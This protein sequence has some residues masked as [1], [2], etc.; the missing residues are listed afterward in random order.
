MFLHLVGIF[1]TLG[2]HQSFLVDEPSTDTFP[3]KTGLVD[4]RPVT[5]RIVALHWRDGYVIHH[6]IGQKL[7]DERVVLDHPLDVRKAIVAGDYV[8]SSPDDSRFTGG[9]HPISVG[10]KSKGT[11]FAWFID[12]W[13]DGRAVNDRPDF[14]SEHWIYLSLPE[15]LQEG[16]NYEIKNNSG[17]LDSRWTFDL[18][19]RLSD[20]VH[21]NLQGYRPDAP[22]K[23]GYVYAWEGDGGSLDIKTYLGK[24]FHVIDTVSGRSVFD[25]RVKF[26]A[27]LSN[28]ETA[29]NGDT[30]NQN[31]LGADV[32]ECDF[33][34]F[35]TPGSYTLEVED[36]GRSK[37][38]S[39]AADVYRPAFKA[40]MQGL[41]GNRSGIELKPPNVP[42]H[43]PAPHN[44]LVTPGFAGKLKYTRSRYLDRTDPDASPAD[45]PAV[46]AGIVGD[47]DV[48][49]WYQDAGDW[50]CYESHIQVPQ[51]LMLGYLLAPRNFKS[52]ELN[53]PDPASPL[54][55]LLKEASWLPKFCYRLRH[56]LLRRKY[57]TGGI[58]LRI[59]GD[60][61]GGD[62]GP[63]DVGRGSWQDVDRIWTASGEDPVSTFGY[64]GIAA[65][66]A[67]CLRRAGARD[68]VGI[69]WVKEAQE[70]FAWAEEHSKPGDEKKPD[71]KEYR[72][73]ALCA[74]ALVSSEPAYTQMLMEGTAD[75]NGSSRLW[76]SALDGPAL[77]LVGG[78]SNKNPALVSRFRDAVLGT[79]DAELESA[80]RRALRW[81]GDWGMPMLV[82]QQTTPW[83]AAMAVA[84]VVT[85]A[86][87]PE[88]SRRYLG[89]VLT[90][91]DYFM[92]T[93]PLNQTWVTGLGPASPQHP[94]TLDGWYEDGVHPRPGIIPYGPWRKEKDQASG[95][96]EHDW[97]NKSVYPAIDLWPGGERWFDSQCCPMTNEFTIHQNMA[98]AALIYGFLCGKV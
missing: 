48:S 49:G 16:R 37:V 82:G 69:E 25:G 8:V 91:A 47:L 57:G 66:F 12:K 65:N 29:T 84:S 40:V 3:P 44:P 35:Q 92:G 21:V 43:R 52:G 50:D 71:Y 58:G 72:I 64:A 22:S 27:P 77:Y 79:A 56:E 15:P 4:V 10:R 9:L 6:K 90:T 86:S 95:P 89:A 94:F 51:S 67:L 59:C 98:P 70:S 34:A 80:N 78:G 31:F 83:V 2:V 5:N 1:T 74:L 46:E 45:R 13:V 42:F 73:Y 81:G 87:E 85:G 38:F 26:R 63:G 53:L 97:A 32:A 36:V 68:T 76:W 33:S 75:L 62:T 54:P 55:D 60:Y 14:A 7:T 17:G 96:W 23:F 39:I 18:K 41:L 24:T 28:P 20:A 30:P 93:N 88:R 61:F 19:H 11:D